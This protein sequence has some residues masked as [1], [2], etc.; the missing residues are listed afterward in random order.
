MYKMGMLLLILLVFC[1]MGSISANDFSYPFDQDDP[2]IDIDE[3]QNLRNRV[4]E[5]ERQVKELQRLTEAPSIDGMIMC[6]NFDC[7]DLL[8]RKVKMW[9]MVGE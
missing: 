5:L 7:Y 6:D 3:I 2:I 1:F 9:S 8:G 4:K